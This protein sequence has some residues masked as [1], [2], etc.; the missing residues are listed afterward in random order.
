MRHLDKLIKRNYASVS[1]FV[2]VVLSELDFVFGTAG[3]FANPSIP[4]IRRV[5]FI[6]LGN[7]NRSA[8]ASA[9]CAESG[10]H[11]VSFGLSTST[12]APAFHRA[13]KIAAEM[14]FNLTSHKAVGV[15]DFIPEH[16]DLY[17]V[18]EIRHAKRLVSLGLPM[19]QI[20]LL[21][22]W[23]RPQRL[24][25][26]DPF[27][28]DE[29]YFRSCFTLVESAVRNL[30]LEMRQA[31]SPACSISCSELGIRPEHTK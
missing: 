25:I 4:N 8:F 28:H 5:V 3:K 1:G 29:E 24:H 23:S 21:G 2:R 20:A 13:V 15:A 18:M 27:E 9:V 10:I 19:S 6:C 31:S 16:G 7:I 14:G 12:G 30:A 26:H 22:F 11:T 17:L